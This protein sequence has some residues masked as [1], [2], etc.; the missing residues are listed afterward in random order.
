MSHRALVP[1]FSKKDTVSLGTDLGVAPLSAHA[2][3]DMK[4]KPSW[5]PENSAVDTALAKLPRKEAGSVGDTMFPDPSLTGSSTASHSIVIS[6]TA[7]VSFGPKKVN[8]SIRQKSRRRSLAR[9]SCRFTENESRGSSTV[10]NSP[11]GGMPAL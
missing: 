9:V 5:R 8:V 2:G 7:G 11:E 10:Q 3:S 6:S 4:L 1:G